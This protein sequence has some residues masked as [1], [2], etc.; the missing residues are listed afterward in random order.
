[1]IRIGVT[2]LAMVHPYT[3]RSIRRA[4]IRVMREYPVIHGVTCLL[5]GTDRIFVD[6]VRSLHGSFEAILP[7]PEISAAPEEDRNLRLLLRHASDVTK[8]TAPGPPEASFEAARRE[9]VARSDLMIAVW[10]GSVSDGHGEAAETVA[11]ARRRGTEVRTVW[12]VGA[13]PLPPAIVPLTAA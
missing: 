4:L 10:D 12:P 7:V 3:H 1:M 13:R 6:A 2:G 8:M 9:V 5:E 11:W